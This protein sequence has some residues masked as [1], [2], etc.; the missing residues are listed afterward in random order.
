MVD[1]MENEFICFFTGFNLCNY[2]LHGYAILQVNCRGSTGYGEQF[3]HMLP[4][5]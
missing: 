1:H 5:V 4:K 2:M 3:L